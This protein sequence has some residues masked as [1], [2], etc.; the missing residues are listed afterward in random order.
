MSGPRG[1]APHGLIE[2]TLVHLQ[3]AWVEREQEAKAMRD[4]GFHSTAAAL[5]LYSLE[6]LVKVVICKRLNLPSLPAACKSHN[7]A[8]LLVFT[9]AW[10]EMQDPSSSLVRL[11]WDT[12]VEA[13]REGLNDL[14][15]Q[16]REELSL[17]AA[18]EIDEALDEPENGV[19]AWLLKHI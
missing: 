7:L 10:L 16:P 2:T 1:R 15:Y 19:L 6:I 5:R 18:A 17:E 8:E 13:S 4:L 9:G 12:L 14:R 11:N 3:T